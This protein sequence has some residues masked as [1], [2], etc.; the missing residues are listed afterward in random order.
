LEE[1]SDNIPFQYKIKFASSM[2]Y[3]GNVEKDPKFKAK[4][5]QFTLLVDGEKKGKELVI[6][7]ADIDLAAFSVPGA[8]ESEQRL[9]L[10]GKEKKSS[11]RNPAL[12]LDVSVE[13]LKVNGK[14]VT[15]DSGSS[16]KKSGKSSSKTEP[17]AADDP[18]GL[19]D[20]EGAGLGKKN[21]KFKSMKKNKNKS[22]EEMMGEPESISVGGRELTLEE[23][24]ADEMSIS[25]AESNWDGDETDR[26]YLDD[27]EDWADEL[28]AEG[29]KAF[30]DEEAKDSKSSKKA[31][32]GS[33]SKKGS[34]ND[35]DEFGLGG[36]SFG[37]RNKAA[38]TGSSFGRR[39]DDRGSES[40]EGSGDDKKNDDDDL[41]DDDNDGI[42][43]SDDGTYTGRRS[44]SSRFLIVITDLEDDRSKKPAAKKD[45]EP[46]FTS[47]FQ[48]T[49]PV[50]LPGL[51]KDK[52]DKGGKSPRDSDAKSDNL[53]KWGTK[54]EDPPKKDTKDADK[55]KKAP[56]VTVTTPA[57]S[58]RAVV[59]AKKD[60]G[61]ISDLQNR[62]NV[63]EAVRVSYPLSSI[64]HI[65]H[66]LLC[67][68][69]SPEML[70]KATFIIADGS[71]TARES[72]TLLRNSQ[73][74]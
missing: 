46:T 71:M 31:G 42:M 34:S 72:I 32:S 30:A 52:D 44:E 56:G 53:T 5:M 21:N 60:S 17:A 70:L 8:F 9:E 29:D 69:W 11:A 74:S 48:R 65:P 10:M 54:K 49:A 18:F 40:G 25:E 61:E 4:K 50:A 41:L 27:D 23:P 45:P 3:D 22:P 35:L 16:K 39:K 64:C 47:S 20:L 37:K 73:H 62:I 55:G 2:P 68:K 57:G 67:R 6:G 15:S 1:G 33:S 63:L 51:A 12:M 58:K 59:S 7:K 24:D 36:G 26:D 43:D 14:K 13:W 38:D 66:L 19:D 28:A